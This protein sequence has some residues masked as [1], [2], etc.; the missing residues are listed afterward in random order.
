MV[1]LETDKNSRVQQLQYGG[2]GTG[3]MIWT[4]SVSIQGMP[5][6]DVT[7]ELW[8]GDITNSPGGWKF[9]TMTW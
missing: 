2:E 6:R 4:N 9:F 8:V 5:S 1:R 7:I 3:D